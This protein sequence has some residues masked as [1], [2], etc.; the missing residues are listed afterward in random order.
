MD[1]RDPLSGA[2]RTALNEEFQNG[3]KKE[4]SKGPEEAHDN[5]IGDAYTFVAIERHSKLV[6]AWHLGRRTS[7][8]TLAF[9]EKVRE[10]CSPSLGAA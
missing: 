2:N 9:T 7:R 6:I 10:G 8:D 1:A 5:T 4:A 3:E